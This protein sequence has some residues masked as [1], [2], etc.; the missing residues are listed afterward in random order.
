MNNEQFTGYVRSLL[1]FDFFLFGFR[2]PISIPF[3]LIRCSSSFIIP[4]YATEN[5]L[6]LKRTSVA[7]IDN[8]TRKTEGMK[9]DAT[10]FHEIHFSRVLTFIYIYIY[11]F[12]LLEMKITV[13]SLG[14]RLRNTGS[15]DKNGEN[16]MKISGY[17][18]L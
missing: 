6:G 10:I 15:K 18:I 4:R 12:N 1:S 16:S 7:P 17:V 9:K 13:K 5:E 8:R 14:E 2:R 3:S 11:K